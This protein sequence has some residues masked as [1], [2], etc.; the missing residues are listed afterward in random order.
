MDATAL[1]SALSLIGGFLIF[2]PLCE[3]SH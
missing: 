1:C 2:L 3:S